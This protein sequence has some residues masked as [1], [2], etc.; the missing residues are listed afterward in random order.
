MHCLK[1]DKFNYSG[2]NRVQSRIDSFE[3]VSN[4]ITNAYVIN[5][6]VWIKTTR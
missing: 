5:F 6:K 1:K 2:A 4:K 3:Y